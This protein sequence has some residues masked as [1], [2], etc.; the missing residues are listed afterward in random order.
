[1]RYLT[2]RSDFPQKVHAS[3]THVAPATQRSL[4]HRPSKLIGRALVQIVV[5]GGAGENKLISDSILLSLDAARREEEQGLP[6]LRKVLA[7]RVDEIC[8]QPERTRCFR[9]SPETRHAQGT[10]TRLQECQLATPDT[11]G[12]LVSTETLAVRG[13]A[14]HRYL[15][16]PHM[17]LLRMTIH[18]S[19]TSR[20]LARP[21]MSVEP[22]NV[23]DRPGAP[24]P[25]FSLG[26]R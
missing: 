19:Q 8:I 23:Q 6:R 3:P 16:S 9:R 10:L 15:P 26:R 13:R 7:P 18:C 22:R 14:K 12:A 21:E 5:G 20:E 24:G 2:S 25:V 1:M 4:C 17:A 11:Q